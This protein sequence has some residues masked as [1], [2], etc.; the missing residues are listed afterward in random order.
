METKTST[1]NYICRTHTQE[2]PQLIVLDAHQ[3]PMHD[4]RMLE[5]EFV[6]VNLI[7]ELRY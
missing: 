1:T 3:L 7:C 6:K 5:L 4:E 2:L